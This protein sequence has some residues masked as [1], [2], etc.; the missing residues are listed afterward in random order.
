[1]GTG[2]ASR[3]L[4]LWTEIRPKSGRVAEDDDLESNPFKCETLKTKDTNNLLIYN[5]IT[6]NNLL[7][8]LNDI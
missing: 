6:M 5:I 1:M 4:I 7:I 2:D 8:K 3:P